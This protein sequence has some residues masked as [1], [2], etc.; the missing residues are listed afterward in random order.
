MNILSSDCIILVPEEKVILD[1]ETPNSQIVTVITQSQR[2][3][4]T[5][6]KYNDL[7]FE[8]LTSRLSKINT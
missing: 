4:F 3:I 6:I 1:K 8:V 5:E 7:E 2:R